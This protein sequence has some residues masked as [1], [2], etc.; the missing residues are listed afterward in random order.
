[1]RRQPDALALTAGKRGSRSIQCQV[2]QPALQQEAQ[3]AA[4]F[5]ECFRRDVLLSVV[6]F[7][8]FEEVVRFRDAKSADFRQ[9]EFFLRRLGP[10]ADILS[11]PIQPRAFA[12]A[13]FDGLH[14]FF[15]LPAPHWVLRGAVVVQQVGNQAG[16]F[17][18]VFPG[19]SRIAPAKCDVPIA[20][21]VEEELLRFFGQFVPCGLLQHGVVRHA[22]VGFDGVAH[23]DVDVTLPP[24]DF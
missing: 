11:L 9:A 17:A 14:E 22:N 23:T 3:P 8:V 21:A 15:K 24:T 19:S 16:P 18:A 6:E 20:H 1:M 4:D 10:D 12:R 7:Q 2:I 5:F 13:A